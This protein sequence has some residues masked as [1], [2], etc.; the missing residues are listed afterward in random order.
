MRKVRTIGAAAA[1]GSRA[2]RPPGFRSWPKGG[3]EGPAGSAG[4]LRGTGPEREKHTR[5]ENGGPSGG[6]PRWFMP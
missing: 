6:R 2:A 3:A 5:Q 4:F 1:P